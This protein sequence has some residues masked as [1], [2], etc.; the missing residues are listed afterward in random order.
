MSDDRLGV[1]DSGPPARRGGAG[2]RYPDRIEAERAA[3]VD[4]APTRASSIH[5]PE[6][7]SLT[8]TLPYHL[9]AQ[10]EQLG[11]RSNRSPSE[12]IAESIRLYLRTCAARREHTRISTVEGFSYQQVAVAHA[13]AD[14]APLPPEDPEPGMRGPGASVAPPPAAA[15]ESPAPAAAPP[16]E[17]EPELNF[18]VAV[19][20]DQLEASEHIADPAAEVRR[21]LRKLSG[22]DRDSVRLRG[23][24]EDIMRGVDV[25]DYSAGDHSTSVAALARRLA[26]VKG[27]SGSALLD[28]WLGGL[29]HDIGKAC[30]PDDILQKRRPGPEEMAVIRNYPQFGAE[31]LSLIPSLH[32]A[33]TLVATHQE[34]WNGSGYPDGLQGNDIPPGAQI[35]AIC[36]VYLVLTTA[37]RYRPAYDEDRARQI[38]HQAA[39]TLWSPDLARLFLQHVIG[40]ERVA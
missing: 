18:P 30:I 7:L 24:L 32:N 1:P 10:L 5:L 25:R 28:V 2:D 33:A 9:V 22:E 16:S 26:E 17:P 40:R 20:L 3:I 39:G 37:R 8:Y 11:L 6:F 12:L 36:D 15:A 27:I 35:V 31:L 21:R 4:P 29:L 19:A 38:I 23:A 14:D 34:R 13:H